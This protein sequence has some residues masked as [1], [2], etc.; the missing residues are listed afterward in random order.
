MKQLDT[1]REELNLQRTQPRLRIPLHLLM[2]ILHG[3][4]DAGIQGV[5]NLITAAKRAKDANEGFVVA[6]TH[7]SGLDVPTAA[8]LASKIGRVSISVA[9]TNLDSRKRGV[10]GINPEALQYILAGR[11]NFYP[12]PYD[13]QTRSAKVPRRFSAEDYDELVRR[14]CGGDIAVVSAFSDHES[15]KHRKVGSAAAHTA[16]AAGV[17]IVPMIVSS[18]Q[19][20]AFSGGASLAVLRDHVLSINIGAPITTTRKLSTEYNGADDE[21]K[22]QIR[23]LIR[24]EMA[25]V[26]SL[27]TPS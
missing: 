5:E 11:E 13:W 9:S 14:V 12:V 3:K 18:N 25:E 15:V 4:V 16:L 27:E 20:E 21:G 7:E 1:A 26:Y 19:A 23:Q 6:T 2:Y 8:Y 24:D 22:A 17:S 10:G